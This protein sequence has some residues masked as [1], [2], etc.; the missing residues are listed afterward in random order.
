MWPVKSV[1]GVVLVTSIGRELT[2]IVLCS[3]VRLL[4]SRLFELEQRASPGGVGWSGWR[5]LEV[6][7]AERCSLEENK[8]E[9]EKKNQGPAQALKRGLACFF[10][11]P[12]GRCD[13]HAM[14]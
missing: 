9:G 2:S 4:L 13:N 10:F 8:K 14:R 12:R 5:R 6:E 1:A 7:T 11:L 3:S